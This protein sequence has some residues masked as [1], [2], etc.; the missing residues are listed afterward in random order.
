MT[1]LRDDVVSSWMEI[2]DKPCQGQL[3]VINEDSI[4]MVWVLIKE[5][6]CIT[7]AEIVWCFRDVACNPLSHGTVI[8]ITHVYLGMRK[9]Y[10][11]WVPKLLDEQYKLNRVLESLD[12]I[13]H[14][15]AEGEDLFDLIITRDEKWVHYFTPEMKSASKQW[16]VKGDN[17]PVKVSEKERLKFTSQCFG[18][19][20]GH[21]WKNTP[22]KVSQQWRKPTSTFFWTIRRQSRRNIMVNCHKV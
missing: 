13:Y 5:N 11:R 21:C 3:S 18:T 12:S 2:V 16:V 4:N 10:P 20:K 14:H 1:L 7:I 17:H 22:Q 19:T 8:K 9:T 6:E 15:H